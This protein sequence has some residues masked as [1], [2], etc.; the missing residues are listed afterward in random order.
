MKKIYEWA[1][2]QAGA[3]K[4]MVSAVNML[5][6]DHAER[7]IEVVV[8]C[9]IKDEE[10][11]K[12]F[13]YE[14][15]VYK[16]VRANYVRDEITYSCEDSTTKYFPTQEDADKYTKD[17]DYNYNRCSFDLKGEYT[18]KGVWTRECEYTTWYT[19]WF[20]WANKSI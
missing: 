1:L 9:E 2:K 14:G 6:T 3:T 19:R 13:T 4:T 20:E 10:I 7:F 12:E 18:F 17:G 8:G 15:K 16:F 5:T 11:P